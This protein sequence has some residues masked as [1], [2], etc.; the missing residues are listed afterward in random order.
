MKKAETMETTEEA[1]KPEEN[2]TKSPKWVR[3]KDR[4]AALSPDEWRKR[5]SE[6]GATTVQ[7]IPTWKEYSRL[8]LEKNFHCL[9]DTLSFAR[10]IGPRV[11]KE[12]GQ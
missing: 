3:V 6:M 7:D 10:P 5:W 9:V 4:L 11:E 8:K 2:P 12:K 1:P